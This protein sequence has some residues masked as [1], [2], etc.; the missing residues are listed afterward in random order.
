MRAGVTIVDPALDH[1]RR[2]GG[3]R[4]RHGRRAVLLPAR[5]HDASASG[6]T[7]GALTTIVDSELGDGVTV[8][9][10]HLDRARV[11]ARATVGPFAYLR[12]DAELR[13]G[14]KAGTFVEIKNSTIGAGSKVPHL[15]YIGDADIGE[16]TNLGASHDH[17]QLRRRQQ[18]PHHDRRPRAHQRGHHVRRPGDRRRRR[19]HRRRLGD[20][21]RRPARRAGHR[22]RA[23]DATSRATRSGF[24]GGSGDARRLRRRQVVHS[25]TR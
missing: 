6:C 23:P 24:P 9:R 11:H 19:V 14:A 15:S 8:L 2:G 22:P 20:H 5:R 12:P 16:G 1:D 3:D 25:A 18:A 10:S 17:R 13:E 21:R 4:R 7:I